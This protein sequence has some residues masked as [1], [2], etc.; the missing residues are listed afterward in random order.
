MAV[1]SGAPFT[2]GKLVAVQIID[3]DPPPGDAPHFGQDMHATVG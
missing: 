3:D 2:I 1:T